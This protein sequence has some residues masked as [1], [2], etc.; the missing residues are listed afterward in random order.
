MSKSLRFIAGVSPVPGTLAGD[1]REFVETPAVP[2]YEQ[3]LA[4]KISGK[5]QAFSSK[6]DSLSNV[7]VTVGQ[8]KAI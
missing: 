1:L 5:L 8:G 2:G 4:G 6:V 7:V 3:E